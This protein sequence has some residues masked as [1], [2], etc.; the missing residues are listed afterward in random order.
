MDNIIELW[1]KLQIC[2]MKETTLSTTSLSTNTLSSDEPD[3]RNEPPEQKE[4]LMT[5]E[6]QQPEEKHLCGGIVK[7]W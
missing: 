1:I 4:P 7:L 6:Q 3:Y 2:K 5:E